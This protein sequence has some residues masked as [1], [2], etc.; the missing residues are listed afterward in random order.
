MSHALL[1]CPPQV[2]IGSLTSLAETNRGSL[3]SLAYKQ[4]QG[5]QIIQD[6]SSLRE[7][8]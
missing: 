4:R 8:K 7:N 2:K 1:K 6:N 3:I 5:K